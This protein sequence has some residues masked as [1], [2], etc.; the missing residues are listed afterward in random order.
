MIKDRFHDRA[1]EGPSVLNVQELTEKA[2]RSMNKT[3]TIGGVTVKGWASG[4]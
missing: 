2:W 4:R 1:V 3:A